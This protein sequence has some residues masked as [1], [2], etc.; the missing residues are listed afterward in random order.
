MKSSCVAA[1]ALGTLFFFITAS[2]AGASEPCPAQLVRAGESAASDTFA[3]ALHSTATTVASA[4]IVADT[5]AGWYGWSVSDVDLARAAEGV[6]EERDGKTW[7]YKGNA[8]SAL[9]ATFAKPVSVRHAWVTS[10]SVDGKTIA[11]AVPIFHARDSQDWHSPAAGAAPSKS[12]AAAVLP[13]PFS[14]LECAKPFADAVVTQAVSPD[15]PKFEILAPLVVKVS[16]TVDENGKNVA[17][18]IYQS[19]KILAFDAA[20]LRSARLST[21]APA[22][23]YCRNV[24]GTYLGSE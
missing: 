16:V 5:D 17:S 13:E 11:C 6:P 20:A 19:S 12:V 2:K 21:Y 1:L 14:T 18:S 9:G 10:A 7:V 8:S 24:T 4:T 23:S 15:Y 3:Y 22:V